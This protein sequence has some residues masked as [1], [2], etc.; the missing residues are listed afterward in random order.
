MKVVAATAPSMA[1]QYQYS[2]MEPEFTQRCFNYF[3]NG[4]R[5]AA[6][7]GAKVMTVNAGW[8]YDGECPQD[9]RQRTIAL[10]GRL[11][12]AAAENGVILALEPLTA[13]ESS[14]GDTLDKVKDIHRTVRQGDV[15]HGSGMECGRDI[16]RLVQRVRQRNS[17]HALYRL[18]T[19]EN[20]PL[21]LGRRRR[22]PGK[23][24]AV[25]GQAWL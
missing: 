18:R 9:G 4:I 21:C 12:E 15:R 13:M 10:L 24:N 19:G 17:S 2:P 7:L 25:F 1:Y 3:S 22:A 11:A 16:G 5:A 8:G 6:E 23:A 14:I 20:G